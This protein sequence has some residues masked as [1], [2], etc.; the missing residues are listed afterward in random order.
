[1]IEFD[2]EKRH[3]K[4]RM[5]FRNLILIMFQTLITKIKCVRAKVKIAF[6]DFLKKLFRLLDICSLF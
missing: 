2:G 5:I 1:M 6:G 3:F 4:N